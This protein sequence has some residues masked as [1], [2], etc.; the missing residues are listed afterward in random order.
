MTKPIH[1]SPGFF[2]FLQELKSHNQRD[3][4]IKNKARYESDVRDPFLHLLADLRHRL[5]KVSPHFV[6]DSS[7]VGGSMMRIHRD[8]RFSKDKSP[9]KTSVSA[10]FWHAHGKEGLTPAFYLHL[11]PGRSSAG[12]GLWRPPPEGLQLIRQAIVSR[13]SQWRKVVSG[14]SFRMGC[15]MAGES[16]K[17]PPPGFDAAHPFIEDIK[18][19]D[20]ATSVVLENQDL[21]RQDAVRVVLGALQS[22]ASFVRFVTEA[23]GLTF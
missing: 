8:V 12:G 17:R 3:W 4:F 6:V 2:R 13:T 14:R 23:L 10:H 1:F 11:E 22:S 9:Y 20:F 5:S 18:R 15:G 16:L 7:P 19:K 21:L